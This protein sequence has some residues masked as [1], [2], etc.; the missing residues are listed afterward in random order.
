MGCIDMGGGAVG[1]GAWGDTVSPAGG[2]PNVLA[3]LSGGGGVVGVGGS[4]DL[5]TLWFG[6]NGSY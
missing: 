5:A 2:S 1:V 3:G 6:T 4:P